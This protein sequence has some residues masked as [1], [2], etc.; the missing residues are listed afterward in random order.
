MGQSE[1]NE[2]GRQLQEMN[3]F[4]NESVSREGNERAVQFQEM[5]RRLESETMELQT[6][7]AELLASV[8]SQLENSRVT[9][10]NMLEAERTERAQSDEKLLASQQELE[11]LF[12]ESLDSEGRARQEADAEL[13][14]LINESITHEG[15]VR[16]T[17]LQELAKRQSDGF[18]AQSDNIQAEQ[19]ARQQALQD[20]NVMLTNLINEAVGRENNERNKQFQDLMSRLEA[21]NA[22]LQNEYF[23]KHQELLGLLRAL[24]ASHGELSSKH[25]DA[26]QL[27][28]DNYSQL[29]G[30]LQA[31]L[32]EVR[33]GLQ[34][35][36]TEN[37]ADTK[38]WEERC[39]QI[40]AFAK[41]CAAETDRLRQEVPKKL[42]Q[43]GE[44]MREQTAKMVEVGKQENA[45][46]ISIVQ[47]IV[48]GMQSV[49][50]SERM[51][52]RESEEE[53]MRTMQCDRDNVR[54]LTNEVRT[55]LKRDL[56]K[57]IQDR[58][59]ALQE[60]RSEILDKMRG[61]QR[62]KEVPAATEDITIAVETPTDGSPVKTVSR[63]A[64]EL[65]SLEEPEERKPQTIGSLGKRLT[66]LGSVSPKTLTRGS[67][68]T[69]QPE[70]K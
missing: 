30:Q 9:Y 50:D 23:N 38:S 37:A 63:A 28:M 11:K 3:T 51:K 36:A 10:H 19:A 22:D 39:N 46:K 64:P 27:H 7:L 60:Q 16:N 66:M 58:Q 6:K 24:E 15:E 53:L 68:T 32:T 17:Q 26:H 18:Q 47:G 34:N 25:F 48:N 54:R 62:K 41:E 13:R 1:S 61:S 65:I 35:L 2:R 33:N 4:I 42:S 52:D 59:D 31:G 12:R 70:V 43:F 56:A 8:E 49:I 21:G 5:T 57:E 67:T 20:L 69:L 45:K 44:N 55:E 14:S 40:D 29:G